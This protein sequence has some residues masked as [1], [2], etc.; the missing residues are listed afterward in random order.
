MA[1]PGAPSEG[2]KG[3]AAGPGEDLSGDLLAPGVG[4]LQPVLV[5]SLGEY[6][7]A[8]ARRVRG[9][10]SGALPII[11]GLIFI[12]AIFQFESSEFLTAS[13]IVTLLTEA[14]IFVL[15]GMAEIF[16]LLLSEIDLSIGYVAG[17]GAFVV[18]ELMATPYNWPWWAAVAIGLL[19]TSAI[20]LLQGTL[21]TRLRIPSFV[22]TLA[23]LLG[24]QG[25][26]IYLADVDKTAVGGVIRI[27]ITNVIFEIVNSNI[28]PTVSW[29]LLVVIVSVF[30]AF[31]ITRDARRR[32]SGLSAPP[33]S[34]SVLTIVVA[35]VA[36]AG[37]VYVCNLTR[38]SVGTVLRGV[39]YVVPFVL[40]VLVAWT[41]VLGRTKL[42]RYIYAIG[43]NP[44][45]ARRAG[46]NVPL[47][48][49]VAF[50]LCSLTAG[51][52]GLVYESRLGSIATDINGG[53]LVLLAV[54]SAVIGGT[55]LFGGRGKPVHALLG[56][57]V[58]AVVYN[59][60]SLLGVSAAGLDMATALVLLAAVTIDS[61]VRGRART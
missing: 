44:E 1:E 38:G 24:W 6:L 13:N 30:G 41:V 36:S 15:L 47:V 22:V 4:G 46:V 16:A 59:G 45:A 18:A 52:A 25:F 5:G 14:P 58:I 10:D 53:N 2:T 57:L 32:R 37:L 27:P 23:G 9:G 28:N 56:G 49:T 19:A 51:L 48:R 29:F 7:R 21:I 42:G 8:W 34:I 26:M 54:A 11:A 39:P 3:D 61:L 35:A 43:A 17:V 31:V 20:G 12:V 55:S 40:V 33:L 60:L 50:T